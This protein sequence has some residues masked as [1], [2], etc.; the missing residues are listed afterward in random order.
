MVAGA[1]VWCT[2]L[3]ALSGV[4]WAQK[5]PLAAGA[6]ARA[7]EHLAASRFAQA[8][9]EM[10]IAVR[11][12]PRFAFGWYLLASASR[13]AGQCDRAVAAY[14]RYAELRPAEADPHFG[15]GLCLRTVGDRDGAIAAFKR[16]LATDTRTESRAFVEEARKHLGELEAARAH[17]PVAKPPAGLLEARHLSEQGRTDQAIR[18]LQDLATA[19]PKAAEVH[20]ELGHVLVAARRAKEAIAPLQTAVRLAPAAAPTWYDLAFALREAGQTGAAVDAYRRYITLRPQDPDPHYGLGRTLAMLG[21]NDEALA[22][23]RA[24]TAL[25]KRPTERRWVKK[26]EAEI[27]RLEPARRPEAGQQTGATTPSAQHL[28]VAPPPHATVVPAAP[29]M[30]PPPHAAAP[31]APARAPALHPTPS[32]QPAPNAPPHPAAALPPASTAP[33]A[34]PAQAAPSGKPGH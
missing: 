19:D 22:A 24:Y 30:T 25:E 28:P 23:F 5:S 4:A 16:Y 21:R 27:A 1:V 7:N 34:T 15:I 26:A 11:F 20:A 9:D 8:A 29:S 32:P 3:A 18:Q 13:R 31:P 2:L 17:A 14:R 12:E 6:Y 33:S 10:E